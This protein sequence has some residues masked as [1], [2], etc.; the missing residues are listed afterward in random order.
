MTQRRDP[1]RRRPSAR[2]SP[3]RT[4]L[5]GGGAG[6]IGC[7]VAARLAHAGHDVVIAGRHAEPLERPRR[8]L[9]RADRRRGRAR[10]SPTSP[11]PGAAGGAA[12]TRAAGSARP[13]CSS[14]TRAAHR[15]AG[16]ST[17]TT[18]PGAA[19]CEL[20]LL[21]PLRLA[22]LGAA[23]DGARGYGRLVVVTSTAVRQ[24]QPDLAV[25]VVLRSAMTAAAKLLAPESPPTA[26][27]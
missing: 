6:G 17:S 4:A 1:P 16:S 14:S 10:W 9:T 18:T 8:E 22:R 12:P 21:G 2:A 24:P 7:A 27:P 5:V 25:S 20:L 11:T 13:T 3:A 23:R 15:P 26:S 19:G